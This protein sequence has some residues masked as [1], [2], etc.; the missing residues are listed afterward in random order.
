MK[1]CGNHFHVAIGTQEFLADLER[2]ATDRKFQGDVRDQ[3]L[4]LIDACASAFKDSRDVRLMGFVETHMMLL[5]AG[6]SF[7]GRNVDNNVP[8]ITPTA[9]ID[10]SIGTK[11]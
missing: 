4:T 1:N 8:I 5:R 2:V 11:G 9:I 10:S 7:P 6:I 3:A